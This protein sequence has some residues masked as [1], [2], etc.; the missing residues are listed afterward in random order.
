MPPLLNIMK[1]VLSCPTAPFR[2]NWVLGFVEKELTQMKVPYF[3]D[4]LGNI[5]AG[6]KNKKALK[7]SSRVA[8]LAHTDHPGFHILKAAGTKVFLAQWFGGH[9]PKTK[10]ASVAIYNP[11]IPNQKASGKI[12]SAKFFGKSKNLFKIKIVSSPFEISKE[13][14]GAFAYPGFSLR[15]KRIFT[16]AADD[17]AGV[18][19]ILGTLKGLSKNQR[20][21]ALGIF[22][23]AEEVGFRGTLGIIYNN[24]LG[25]Q[26]SVISLEAS[27]Q[28]PG[29]RIGLG[30]VIRLG[31]KR[32]LF[33]STVTAILDSAAET[34]TK[35]KKS[36]KVQRRIMNGGTCEATPFNLH[37][38]KSAGLAVPLGNYHNQ[39]GTGHP[40]P[41]YV[42]FRDVQ[43]AVDLCIEFYKQRSKKID[44]I[45]DFLG[46][47]KKGYNSDKKYFR[48]KI[49]FENDI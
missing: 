49:R 12:I 39:R 36:F 2:E 11:K 16:R 33:D 18:T 41:E 13:C 25:K 21:Q 24:I 48:E 1:G 46:K 20:R 40:G 23:R 15:K 31:D 32:T 10:N 8:L 17:L 6:V 35:N 42:D 34:L 22:T 4:D 27:R 37:H 9:P 47:M 5:I 43:G 19:I 14:F 7:K 26:N 3:R 38:I 30:P 28:L 44:P 29:A 45:K